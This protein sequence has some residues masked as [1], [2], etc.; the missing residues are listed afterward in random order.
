MKMK[1][2]KLNEK[3]IKVKKNQIKLTTTARKNKLRK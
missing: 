3:K 2:K 1:E